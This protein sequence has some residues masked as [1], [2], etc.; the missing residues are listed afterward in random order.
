[1]ARFLIQEAASH[2][3]DDIYRYT[4]DRWGAKKAEAYVTGLFQSFGRVESRE[5]LSRPVPA[6]FGVK[7]FFFRY[8]KHYVYWKYLNNGDVGI[9]T[10]LHQRMHQ[11]ERFKD[12]FEGNK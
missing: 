4:L 2:R 5:V 1:M 3:I 12:D 11:I 6:D 10:I 9:V 7:G 8:E